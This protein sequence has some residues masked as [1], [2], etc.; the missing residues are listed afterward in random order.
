[1]RPKNK[2]QIADIL[3]IA[4]RY[5]VP[6]S[7]YGGN[8]ELV[9]RTQKR[10]S[11]RY[12]WIRGVSTIDE[13]TLT[14]RV[15]AGTT[16]EELLYELGKK[17][18][19]SGPHLHSGPSA[20]IGG[21]VALCSNGVTGAKYGLVGNQVVGL[22]VVLPNGDVLKTGSGAHHHVKVLL[23]MLGERSHCL[24]IGSHGIFGS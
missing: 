19:T 9:G 21:S 7:P 3:R 10:N 17:G 4:N 11:P 14:V 13:D 12:D 20:T 8:S 1:V 23:D 6:I 15:L 24:F 5:K 22:E 16:W 18:W 2:D